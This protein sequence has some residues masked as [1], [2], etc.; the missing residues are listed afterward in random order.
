MLPIRWRRG[1]DWGTVPHNAGL[2]VSA[3]GRRWIVL[4]HGWAETGAGARANTRLTGFVGSW[5]VSSRSNTISF[6]ACDFSP[7]CTC[8]REKA[9]L[10][11]WKRSHFHLTSLGYRIVD[12]GL[13]EVIPGER[14]LRASGS[15]RV[16][17]TGLLAKR[18]RWWGMSTTCC[19]NERSE[20]ALRWAAGLALLAA[21]GWSYRPTLTDLVDFW[22]QNSDYSAGGL[23]P[24]VA[25][26]LIWGDRRALRK[27]PAGVCWWGLAVLL[28]SQAIRLAGLFYMFGSLERYSLV[29]A[30]AGV[31]LFVFGYPVTRR[32]VWVLLFLLL[33]VP[34]PERVHNHLAIPLQDVATSSSVFCLELL[35]FLVTRQGHVLQLS[36]RTTVA[37]A[38]ACSGLRMLTAF[39]V[40]AATL[41]FL[42]HQSPWKKFIVLIS[43][44]PVAILANTLRLV[45]T[46]LLYEWASNETAEKFFHDF[47]GLTMMPL[48]VVVLV[49]ELRL[50]RWIGKPLP[51]DAE[52]PRGE[53][54]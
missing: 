16:D 7:Q 35:G 5:A 49:L 31:C 28:L 25:I 34:L 3:T 42:V 33:M 51:T 45:I 38:E 14:L 30:V 23:V 11:Y 29:L 13:G 10:V 9:G 54:G 44:I 4:S 15:D 17:R 40:V 52:S 1:A 46:V 19:D 36:E 53:P 50:L 41:A 43:S 22:R 39:V 6:L 12:E 21:G 2:L 32:L 48:A 26:C 37:V 27:L 20:V 47:A 24:L 18:V 8:L